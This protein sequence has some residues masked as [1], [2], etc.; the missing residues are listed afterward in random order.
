MV[1]AELFFGR[2]IEGRGVVSEAQWSDFAATTLAAAFPDGFTVA[3]GVGYWRD[4]ASAT[5]ARE[6]AKIVLVAS[7]NS[8]ALAARL[9][10]VMSAYRAQFR[11]Q[12]VGVVTREVCAAF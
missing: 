6:P 3:D 9:G 4:P 5:E 2:D 11:Q 1:E 10:S 12:A 8:S 7:A